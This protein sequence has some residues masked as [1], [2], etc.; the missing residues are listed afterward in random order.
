LDQRNELEDI[1]GTNISNKGMQRQK[2]KLRNFSGS[3]KK[4]KSV[5]QDFRNKDRI[6]SDSLRGKGVGSQKDDAVY[7]DDEEIYLAMNSGNSRFEPKICYRELI[8][9]S[10]VKA[11]IKNH[12][13]K[14]IIFSRHEAPINW[15][16]WCS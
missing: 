7:L 4:K 12:P 6:N 3:K 2:R 13:S 10:W 15:S 14:H 8:V 1:E 11:L 9:Y 16:R 5:L